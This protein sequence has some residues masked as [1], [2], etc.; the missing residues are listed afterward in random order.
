MSI[1]VCSQIACT[2]EVLSHWT[3]IH[4]LLQAYKHLSLY[5]DYPQLL[6]LTR[7]WI[8]SHVVQAIVEHLHDKALSVFT[9][10]FRIACLIFRLQ[11]CLIPSRYNVANARR[12]SELEWW[13]HFSNLCARFQWLTKGKYLARCWY[14][15]CIATAQL[16]NLV[17]VCTGA[18]LIARV[19]IYNHFTFL[20]LF[21]TKQHKYLSL[22][23]TTRVVILE[24]HVRRRIAS[25]SLVRGHEAIL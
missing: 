6:T 22:T 12:P 25:T 3:D 5:L 11:F 13:Q 7:S 21:F 4:I 9:T 2:V 10:S 15:E 23:I 20:F 18:A 24:W 8:V 1:I 16:A 17:P 14:V 19:Q